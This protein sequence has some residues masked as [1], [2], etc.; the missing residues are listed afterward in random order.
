MN[1]KHGIM[2]IIVAFDSFKGC[3][4]AHDACMSAAKGLHERYPEADVVSVPLSDGGEGLV[5][6]VTRVQ[7]ATVVQCNAH[8]PLMRD[9]N[10]RYAL[11]HD[12]LTAYMEM[13]ETSGLPLLDES[14][15][16]PMI[17]TTYGVGDMIVDA[18][19]RGCR[20]I[21]MGIGGSA[22]CDAGKGMIECLEDNNVDFGALPEVVVACD[23]SNPLY[24]DNGAACIFAPQK[25]ATAEQVVELDNRLR[26]FAQETQRRGIATEEMASMEGTGA[27]GG[28]GY[29][30]IAYLNAK[31]LSG[32]DVVLDIANFDEVIKGAECIITGE[33][34]S[35]AQTLMGKVPFGVL[36]RA[37]KQGV[38]VH[39][40]SGQIEDA[41]SLLDAGFAVVKSINEGDTRPLNVLMQREIAMERL[42]LECAKGGY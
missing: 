40:V 16:N 21:V 20:K 11:S 25:G 1:T 26:R 23:V 8:D 5:E 39:L 36:R 14:E 42:A 38:A 22:T 30:L 41:D 13:A 2:K 37:M 27:A 4:S 35:D 32:I 19:R 7:S 24:G 17:T 29:A 3:M 6:C 9:M 15:R 10:A 34:K 28:L 18:M 31:L 12:G 33:G